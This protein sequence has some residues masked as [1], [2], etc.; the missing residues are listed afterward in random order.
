MMQKQP[1]S[2]T[3]EPP[4]VLVVSQRDL[5]RQIANASLYDFEDAICQFDRATMIKARNVPRLSRKM[6]TS[7]VELLGSTR[8]PEKIIPFPSHHVIKEKYNLLFFV[9]DDFWQTVS[10]HAIKQWR[11]QCEKSACY[12]AEMWEID[13]LKRSKAI[14]SLNAFDHIFV[15]C[16][17]AAKML[18]QIIDKPCSYLPPATNTMVF[19]P[20]NHDDTRSIDVCYVGRRSEITHSALLDLSMRSRLFYYFDP[21]QHL[22][23][24]DHIAHRYLLSCL[25]RQS[26]Y[27]VVN[28]AKINQPEKTLGH[29]EVGYR[30]FEGA[31]G[32]AVMVGEPPDTDTYRQ[33]FDWRDAVIK[34]PFDIPDVAEFFTD[35][36]RQTDRIRRIRRDNAVNSLLRHDCV[37]RWEE[38]LLK[39]DMMP[40]LEMHARKRELAKVA[41]GLD[42]QFG[43]GCECVPKRPP[44]I[45][46]VSS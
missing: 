1:Q 44:P 34:M 11:N 35:L 19:R 24:E 12:I 15:S 4:R 42:R 29:Q 31:A 40:T 9:C 36:D 38:I 7:A 10:L 5:N 13:I 43:Q 16:S 45:A 2:D 26:R 23:A 21:A 14:K 20:S 32:G 25:V 17:H 27:F 41:A 33:L 22:C 46:H 39:M 30:F 8:L 28:Y 37:H 3:K 6:F 18:K